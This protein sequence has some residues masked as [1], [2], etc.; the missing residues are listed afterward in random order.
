MAYIDGVLCA[1]PAAN[2]DAFLA[3]ARETAAI[4]KEVGAVRVVDGWGSDVPDGKVTDFRRAVQASSDEI[5]TFGW[6][7]WPDKETRDAAWAKL[8]EDPRMADMKMPYD[9]KRMVYG[10]FDLIAET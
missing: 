8:M 9:G 4:F 7:E 5:V 2:K 1:V 10:G 6:I 3:H